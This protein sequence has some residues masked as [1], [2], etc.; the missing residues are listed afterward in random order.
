[1]TIFIYLKC[2]KLSTFIQRDSQGPSIYDFITTNKNKNLH[3]EVI[4]K[5]MF[6]NYFLNTKI[7]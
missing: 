1:M 3:Y 7:S 6:L 4:L 5:Y 2:N